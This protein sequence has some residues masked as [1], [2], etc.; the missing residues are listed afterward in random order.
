MNVAIS[1]KKVEIPTEFVNKTAF[2][3]E[4]K[5]QSF[6]HLGIEPF[7]IALVDNSKEFS[8]KYPIVFAIEDETYIGL[9]EKIAEDLYYLE[10]KAVREE[11]LLF[12]LHEIK[13]IGQ[14]KGV[15]REEKF[16]NGFV[17]NKL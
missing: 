3:F 13:L 10:N 6:Q 8:T 11:L 1:L 14:V 15:F 9:P 17:F 16:K 4:V 12:S 7:S 2:L 5:D